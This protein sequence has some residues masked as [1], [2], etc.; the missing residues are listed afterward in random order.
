M[1][2]P[3]IMK[4]PYT[5]KK[6][7]PRTPY[8]IWTRD[9]ATTITIRYATIYKKADTIFYG[10]GANLNKSID[11]N[12]G[13]EKEVTLKGL[14]P[15]T[16]YRYRIGL[17]AKTY[18]FFTAPKKHVP[19]SFVVYGDYSQRGNRKIKL[20]LYQA[21]KKE[22]PNFILFT[23]DMVANGNNPLSWENEFFRTISSMS[24]YFPLMAVPGNHDGKGPLFNHYF[25][26]PG[27]PRWNKLVYGNALFILLDTESDYLPGSPQHKFLIET[28]RESKELLK[29]VGLHKTP[30]STNS[31]HH[32]DLKIRKY[33]CE[34]FEK[35]G[36]NIV[37][38]GHNHGYERTHPIL[39]NQVNFDKGVTYIT[40]GGGGAALIPF[41]AKEHLSQ[42]EKQ[43]SNVRVKSFHYTVIKVRNGKLVILVK[44]LFG[45]TID[46]FEYQ[47][48][49][50]ANL[51][52]HERRDQLSPFRNISQ[53]MSYY[54]NTINMR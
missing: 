43:W 45:K 29:I 17:G 22:H 33:L 9:P 41:I 35:Y 4:L 48:N 5:I 46:S 6:S 38:A 2:Q 34:V 32:S 3:S 28:L 52:G 7:F 12:Y 31:G 47:F 39:K 13:E 11:T 30:Y 40:T 15:G 54:S 51:A 8:L 23:G 27:S 26:Y 42:N 53:G 49:D 24:S 50:K 25:R 18:D 14:I 20:K 36:V 21:I 16:T 19:F 10:I 44:D 37:F 1:P